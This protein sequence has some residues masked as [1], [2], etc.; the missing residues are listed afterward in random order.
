MNRN[1]SIMVILLF[2]L[3]ACNRSNKRDF[4]VYSVD[5][6]ITHRLF[7]EL[8]QG[9]K[10]ANLL[11]LPDISVGVDS[12]EIRIWY[13][14]FVGGT[15]LYNIRYANTRWIANKT[16]YFSI[17]DRLDSSFTSSIKVPNDID[18][19]VLYLTSNEILKLPSQQE[20]PNFIDNVGDGQGCQFE[21][22]TKTFYKS[23]YYHCP[24]HFASKEPNN[25]KFLDLIN[26]INQYYNFYMPWCKRL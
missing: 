14:G 9:Q 17:D 22:A 6:S 21:I 7:T 2:A 26:R 10:K 4:K 25:K 15:S 20:I 24:E 13:W 3:L 12:F 18:K 16:Q 23:L 1:F 19:F 5:T 8:Q 11:N